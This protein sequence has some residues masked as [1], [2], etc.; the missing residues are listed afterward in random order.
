MFICHLIAG[1]RWYTFNSLGEAG[2]SF[3]P[4]DFDLGQAALWISLSKCGAGPSQ[5]GVALRLT[6]FP[7]SRV[8]DDL[9]H[10]FPPP[11][12]CPCTL[13]RQQK[14]GVPPVRHQPLDTALVAEPGGPLTEPERIPS[15]QAEPQGF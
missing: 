9:Q 10:R 5:S 6:G 15:P 13:R 4:S 14:R 12:D 11:G 7:Q 3:G 2:W 8:Q 1:F